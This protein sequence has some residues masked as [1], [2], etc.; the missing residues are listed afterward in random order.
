MDILIGPDVQEG[1]DQLKKTENPQ[2]LDDA[3]FE[4]L[5]REHDEQDRARREEQWANRLQVRAE[6]QAAEEAWRAENP[7]TDAS[8]ES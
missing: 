8:I 6:A 5:R 7:P 2:T 3:E 1:G 4:K